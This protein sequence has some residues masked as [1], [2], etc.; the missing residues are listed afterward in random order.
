MPQGRDQRRPPGGPRFW[1]VLLDVAVLLVGQG[2]SM[3]LTGSSSRRA[4]VATW[5]IFCYVVVS[6]Y[7]GNLTASLTLPKPP[8]RAETVA[9]LDA[10]THRSF[11]HEVFGGRPHYLHC[12]FYHC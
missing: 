2:L 5:L 9:Q 11:T 10:A 8:P 7:N 1:W 4:V 12:Y 6:I 3:R